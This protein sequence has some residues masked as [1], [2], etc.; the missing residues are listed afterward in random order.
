MTGFRPSDSYANK[1]S[2][3][4]FAE[5]EKRGSV[6]D[7]SSDGPEESQ[8]QTVTHDRRQLNVKLI[9]QGAALLIFPVSVALR[10]GKDNKQGHGST[11]AIWC[12]MAPFKDGGDWWRT[13][14][15][16]ESQA[17]ELQIDK[18]SIEKCIRTCQTLACD[19][20]MSTDPNRHHSDLNVLTP[21]AV[22]T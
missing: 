5:C 15:T 10:V 20:S 9:R 11:K 16:E 8:S 2:K 18:H 6:W 19:R 22:Q 14:C 21:A 4:Q 7:E 12:L 13:Q 1:C 17:S 3:T